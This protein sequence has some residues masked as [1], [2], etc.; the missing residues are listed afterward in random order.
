[1]FSMFKRK[2]PLSAPALSEEL[3]EVERET[4]IWCHAQIGSYLGGEPQPLPDL[5]LNH[6]VMVGS[7]VCGFMQGQFI[8]NG[9]L[10]RWANDDS[11]IVSFG[12]TLLA[13]P[14]LTSVLGT[15]DRALPLLN[16]LPQIGPGKFA[17]GVRQ[18]DE[19]GG[20][21]GMPHAKGEPKQKGGLLRFYLENNVE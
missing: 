9:H 12:F 18:M 16:I 14:C 2:K 17:T 7:Y 8:V 1:M 19:M 4:V 20:W 15:N 6:D 3:W 11:D 13:L 21:D 5:G 10:D